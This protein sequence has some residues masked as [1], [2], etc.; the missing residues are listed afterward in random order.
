MKRI[1]IAVLIATGVVVTSL[2][3]T[4]AL[5]ARYFVQIDEWL[6][7]GPKRVCENSAQ[8]EMAFADD[9][10]G[11]YRDLW[12]D[13]AYEN[14]TSVTATISATIDGV[15]MRLASGDA[16]FPRLEPTATVKVGSSQAT[17]LFTRTSFPA[18]DEVVIIEEDFEGNFPTGSWTIYDSDPSDGEHY[19]AKRNCQPFDGLYSGWGVGGGADGSTLPCGAEFPSTAS[20]WMVYGPFSLADAQ[21]AELS[22]QLWLDSYSGDDRV[23]TLWSTDGVTFEGHAYVG[24]TNG[25]REQ[26]VNLTYTSLGDL[27]GEPQVWVAWMLEGRG[28]TA[29]QGPYIDDISLRKYTG[30]ESCQWVLDGEPPNNSAIRMTWDQ[31]LNPGI[32]VTLKLKPKYPAETPWGDQEFRWAVEQCKTWVYLPIVLKNADVSVPPPPTP[33]DP[34]TIGLP[35]DEGFEDGVVP[36]SGWTHVQSNPRETWQIYTSTV[37]PEGVLAA[38]IFY[39][40]LLG[41]QDEVLLSPEFQATSAQ[42]QFYSFGSLYWCRDTY[43][44]CDLNIWLVEGNWGGANDTLI[45]TADDDWAGNFV[46]S[47]SSVD[48]TPY[49]TGETPM[50]IAFQYEGQDGA[51]VALDAIAVTESGALGN[52]GTRTFDSSQYNLDPRSRSRTGIDGD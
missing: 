13:P 48:L 3:L 20:S 26:V 27:T 30:A 45:Y 42:L 43:D 6:Y 23:A 19:W 31:E 47:F 36:P 34:P 7:L 51:Q 24:S 52:G 22:F 11:F 44:N 46:W 32:S 28:S 12:F 33:T 40:D 25:W 39:D 38:T 18:C 49:L 37:P 35:I 10:T 29:G 14:G 2:I 17:F 21:Y 41:Q 1:A 16:I 4:E 15:E 50:R 8:F 9:S 5:Q